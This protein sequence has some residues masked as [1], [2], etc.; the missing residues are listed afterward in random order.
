MTTSGRRRVPF[1]AQ[2]LA[3]PR[4]TLLRSMIESSS[5]HGLRRLALRLLRRLLIGIAAAAAVVVLFQFVEVALGRIS[6][7]FDL[8]W[9]EGGIITHVRRVVTGR[10]LSAEPSLEV[11]AF[12]SPPFCYY[13]SALVSSVVG[14]G[15]FAPRLVSLL[16]ILGS[17]VL[18]GRWVRR[19]TGDH[20]A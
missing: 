14:L 7:P 15:Y 3:L 9:M 13:V 10:P 19:E 8:E 6:Y 2:R 5:V 12:I 17:F 20:L 18:I 11:T 4:L 16:S 1:R